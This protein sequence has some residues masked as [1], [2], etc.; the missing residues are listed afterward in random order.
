MRPCRPL[1]RTNPN[2]L[3]SIPSRRQPNIGCGCGVDQVSGTPYLADREFFPRHWR[4][5][6]RE[7]KTVG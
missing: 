4:K 6:G 5:T 3:P 1:A 7:G 2:Q